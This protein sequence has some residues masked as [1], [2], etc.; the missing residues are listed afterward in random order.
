MMKNGRAKRIL[1]TIGVVYALDQL[2]KILIAKLLSPGDFWVVVPGFFKFVHW[3]N[4]GA[5]WSLLSGWNE[6]LAFISFVALIILIRLRNRFPIERVWG[7][8]AFGMVLGGIFG[9]LTDRIRVGHVIDF[10]YFFIQRDSGRELG[11]PAFN[12]ADASICIGVLMLLILS[13]HTE[14]SKAE[15]AKA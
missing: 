9:N 8:I 6:L 11:F 14:E 5:A 10:L 13:W 3:N 15:G 12:F 1:F 4:T 2:S 7:Q